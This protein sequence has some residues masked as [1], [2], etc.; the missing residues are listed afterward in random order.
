MQNIY[1]S[2]LHTTSEAN[3]SEMWDESGKVG[4]GGVGGSAGWRRGLANPLG[5]HIRLL[6]AM[7]IGYRDTNL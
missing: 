5:A 1:Q 2:K 7:D 4:W 6:H 3:A